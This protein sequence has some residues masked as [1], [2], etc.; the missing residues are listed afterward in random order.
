[1]VLKEAAFSL[2][3]GMSPVHWGC[4][5][6]QDAHPSGD[7]PLPPQ[8]W[9]DVDHSH[10][11]VFI[12]LGTRATEGRQHERLPTSILIELVLGFKL[13]DK[14]QSSNQSINPSVAAC[15]HSPS[16]SLGLLASNLTTCEG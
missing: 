12:C 16:L 4:L 5:S 8:G 1:M 11:T 9:H 3:L 15:A 14:N 7:H 10:Q 2:Q 13:R 6:P